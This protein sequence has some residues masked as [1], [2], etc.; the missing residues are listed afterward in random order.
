VVQ[1]GPG[2]PRWEWRSIPIAFS[3]PVERAQTLRLWLMP[4]ALNLVLAFLRVLLLAA[5]VLCLLGFPGSFWPQALKRAGAAAKPMLLLLGL[6]AIAFTATEVSAAEPEADAPSPA[7]LEQLKQRLLE[8]PECAPTCASSPRLSLEATPKL[9]RMRFELLAGADTA[10]PLPGSA[11]HWVPETVLLD[12]KPAAAMRRSGDALWLAVTQGAHQVLLEGPLPPRDTVQVALPL[13]SRRVEAKLDGWTLD[14]LHEDGLADDNLQ[15]SRKATGAKGEQVALQ[16]GNLPPFVRV[17]RRLVLGLQ[18]TVET[19]LER[20]TPTGS[21]V[22][23]EVPLLPGESVTTVDVRVQ[24]GKALVNIGPSATG[25]AWTSVLNEKSPIAL[26]APQALPW[27]EVWQLDVSPVWHVQTSGIPVVHQ[28]DAEGARLPEWRPWPGEKVSIEVI[29]PDGV[30]GQTLTI[31]Q[32][33]LRLAPGVRATDATLTFNLRSSRGGLHTVTMPADAQLQSVSVNGSVQPIRAEGAK[34]A[35]P[36]VPGSQS[37]VLSWRQSSGITTLYDTPEVQLGTPSVNA[38]LELTLPADR[39]VLF[40]GGPRMGPAVLFWSFFL[41]LLL[42]SI[43]LARIP[44]TPLSTRHWVLLAIG[45]S[46]VPIPAAAVVFGWLLLVGWRQKQPEFR[47]VAWFNLRQLAVVGVTLTA[48]I[49]L[50]VSIRQGL[51]GRPDMQVSGNGSGGGMMRWFDDR[52]SGAFPRGWV[53]SVPMRVYRGAMLGWSLWI[54]FALLRWL[55]W[56]WTS[57][58][59]GGTWK[60]GPPK[61]PPLPRVPPAPPA[62]PAAPA[63]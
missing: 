52:S 54:A 9:L 33:A 30:P 29:K 34:V 51:L 6:W 25:A 50:V 49:I 63:H 42:V 16:I 35:I 14:G 47:G 27:V 7:M 46:Q 1:T 31:D 45:L 60:K 2:R 53:L 15:L 24:N 59:T 55:K 19:T 20:L 21:A 28:Q 40:A 10:V 36:V 8:K 48:L 11:Q 57:F 22:V 44:W 39:W 18:W 4:P 61:P 3:G 17:T 5:L 32:S 62:P 38:D 12:G 13:K 58:T 26:E 41:V 43:G 23:L 37:V 56:T